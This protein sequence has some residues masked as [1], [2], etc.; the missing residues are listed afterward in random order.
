MIEECFCENGKTKEEC[1][2][3]INSNSYYAEIIKLYNKID[4]VIEKRGKNTICIKGCNECC[5]PAFNISK[6]EFLVL[7]DAINNLPN[8]EQEVIKQRIINEWEKTNMT[9]KDYQ[10]KLIEIIVQTGNNYNIIQDAKEKIFKVY[11][12]KC[13]LVDDK[14]GKCMV[15]NSRPI[16][17]RTY[18]TSY[19][20]NSIPNRFCSKIIGKSNI[21][22]NAINIS[23]WRQEIV[24]K[25]Y[26]PKYKNRPVIFPADPLIDMLYYYICFRGTKDIE[27]EMENFS[28]IT[29][30]EFLDSLS[31]NMKKIDFV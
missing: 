25:I 19:Y 24:A 28:K 5:D 15:Y 14:T 18:G 9:Y 30:L 10:N 22:K 16:I 20:K 6:L 11:N 7:I 26:S 12:L 1:H 23:G 3:N 21:E 29:K 4:K 2:N 27:M 17:C 31:D 13:P 8:K